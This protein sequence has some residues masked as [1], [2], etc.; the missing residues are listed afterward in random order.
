MVLEIF[1]FLQFSSLSS[2]ILRSKE[3]VENGM[4]IKSWNGLCALQILIFGKTYGKIFGKS[5]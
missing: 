5:F 1:T 3:E 2:N 4:A